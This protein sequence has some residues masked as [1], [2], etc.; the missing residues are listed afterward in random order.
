MLLNKMLLNFFYGIFQII[1]DPEQITLSSSKCIRDALGL[2]LNILR[3]VRT[4]ME[5]VWLLGQYGKYGTFQRDLSCARKNF[6][7]CNVQCL[8]S[9]HFKCADLG[10]YQIP[11]APKSFNDW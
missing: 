8:A 9:V 11:S 4:T 2:N 1:H 3:I 7:V 5:I 10:C 6:K